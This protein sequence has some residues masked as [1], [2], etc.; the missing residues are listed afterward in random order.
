MKTTRVVPGGVYMLKVGESVSFA[1]M[2]RA[3][4][5]PS[6][7]ICGELHGWG[8]PPISVTEGQAEFDR[9]VYVGGGVTIPGYAK[10]E[11]EL[12]ESAWEDDEDED[13][14]PE[15]AISKEVVS[16]ADKHLSAGDL[17]VGRAPESGS[18]RRKA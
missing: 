3:V 18:R 8:F 16:K 13:E 2:S 11:V 6:G 4:V 17:I 12:P 1:T 5:M 9:W 14:V 10:A 15:Y 7:K